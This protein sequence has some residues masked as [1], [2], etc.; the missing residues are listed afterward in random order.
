MS[1]RQG[2]SNQNRIWAMIKHRNKFED[3]LTK[4]TVKAKLGPELSSEPIP[5]T[6]YST[7]ISAIRALGKN[8]ILSSDKKPIAFTEEE[9]DIL[10]L[11]KD[12]N[13]TVIYFVDE[14]FNFFTLLARIVLE[15]KTR[16]PTSDITHITHLSNKDSLLFNILEKMSSLNYV[17]DEQTIE[18][19]LRRYKTYLGKHTYLPHIISIPATPPGKSIPNYMEHIKD[20]L[21]VNMT[22]KKLIHLF[23]GESESKIPSSIIIHELNKLTKKDRL[24]ISTDLKGWLKQNPGSRLS[25][26]FNPE[27][28]PGT[29]QI[30]LVKIPY[31]KS[32]CICKNCKYTVS[33]SGIDTY[34]ESQNHIAS[35]R[36]INKQSTNG[37]LRTKPQGSLLYIAKKFLYIQCPSCAEHIAISSIIPKYLGVFKDIKDKDYIYTIFEKLAEATLIKQY[38]DLSCCVCLTDTLSYEHVHQNQ[39]CKHEPC[40][41]LDCNDAKTVQGRAIKGNLYVNSNYQCMACTA[42]EPTGNPDIDE[43]NK[44]GGVQ[45]GY[46]GRFCYECNKPFQ[47]KPETCGVEQGNTDIPLY[48][49]DCT[50]ALA[51]Y[52]TKI[53]LTVTCPNPQCNTPISR[54][55]GC[56]VVQCSNENCNI[57]FCYGCE[58]IFNNAPTFEW[59]WECSCVIRYVNPRQYNDKSHSTCEDKYIRYMEGRGIIIQPLQPIPGPAQLPEPAQLYG[60]AQ[61]PIP[62]ITIPDLDGPEIPVPEV[63]VPEVA[64][65]EPGPEP[66]NND[67]IINII[68]INYNYINSGVVAN[69]PIQDIVNNEDDIQ[70]QILLAMQFDDDFSHLY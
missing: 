39:E 5:I 40:I 1:F 28:A 66:E 26:M 29:P 63:A 64:V 44:N 59:Y 31:Y 38:P 68:N 24:D 57:Q 7:F 46:V 58:Y 13:G 55:E 37:L 50:I 47:Q 27:V 15:E 42:F 62:E 16:I 9:K 61:L 19:T 11:S 52:N 53:R 12:N 25:I 43:F 2:P 70:R 60:P 45:P 33:D 32:F 3:Q 30:P 23:P 54:Y 35:F 18:H 56:D 21:V 4:Q 41:C 8:I 65:P 20:K 14:W 48:C 34:L 6:I 51:E 17:Y 22:G 67:I 10:K 49:I 69:P 36:I